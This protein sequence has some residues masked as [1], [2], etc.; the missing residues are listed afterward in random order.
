MKFSEKLMNL[1]KSKGMSQEELAVKLNI[2]RQ[3]VSKWELDQTVPD[4]NK[5]IELS[6]LFDISLDELT[7]NIEISTSENSY[8]E[9]NIEKN[10]KKIAIRIFIVGLIIALVLCGIGYIKQNNAKKINEERR[11]QAGE[12]SQMAIDSAN[13]R[14]KE[15]EQEISLLKNQYN[16]KRNEGDSMDINAPNWFANHSRL[17]D[18]AMDIYSQINELETERFQIEN[19][20]YRV[21]YPLVEP[22]TYNIF[23]YIGA[24]VF[25][26]LSLI[27]LIYFLVTRKK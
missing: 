21:F 24:G 2:T 27:A 8:K 11:I 14:L 3:T 20:D 19:A 9:S 25:A 12:Q 1:R 4:M 13:A 17:Q 10:N 5:L 26:L 15:I 23:Y 6:K 18:E 22:I 7:N 16:E